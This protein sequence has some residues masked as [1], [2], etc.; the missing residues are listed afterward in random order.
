MKTSDLPSRAAYGAIGY[1]D[2][3]DDFV[4]ALYER[5]NPAARRS[6]PTAATSLIIIGDPD[7]ELAELELRA[8]FANLCGLLLDCCNEANELLL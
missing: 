1:V 2:S 3:T 6:T 8:H 5:R 7:R 4:A